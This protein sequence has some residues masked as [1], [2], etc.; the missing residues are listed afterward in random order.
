[1]DLRLA[2]PSSDI[3]ARLQAA[4]AL[5]LKDFMLFEMAPRP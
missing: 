3:L 5:D 4:G 1:V 2:G